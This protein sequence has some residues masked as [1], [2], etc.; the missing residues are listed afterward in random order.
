MSSRSV[1]RTMPNYRS[2]ST[3][4]EQACVQAWRAHEAYLMTQATRADAKMHRAQRV[5]T[6][7][8]LSCLRYWYPVDA[9]RNCM[10]QT[11]LLPWL[12]GSGPH[13]YRK[14]VNSSRTRMRGKTQPSIGV[15]PALP[16]HPVVV[17]LAFVGHLSDDNG[18]D[19]AVIM[20]GETEAVTMQNL[21]EH[22][23]HVRKWIKTSPGFHS[24]QVHAEEF[25]AHLVKESSANLD[26]MT[27][28]RGRPRPANLFQNAEADDEEDAGLPGERVAVDSNDADWGFGD[29]APETA[30]IRAQPGIKYKPYRRIDSDDL[31]H[32]VHRMNEHRT[33]DGRAG[34]KKKE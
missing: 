20:D 11:F 34:D 3:S 4:A 30:K 18:D 9:R 17:I 27:E 5:L 14:G 13:V 21:M 15:L 33:L 28:A 10:V 32:T 7:T 29:E 8:D 22:S 31:F 26:M 6:I 16:Y 24:E 1:G 25:V 19:L 23:A 2:K 12:R